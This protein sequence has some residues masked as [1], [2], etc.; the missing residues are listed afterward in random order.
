MKRPVAKVVL[1]YGPKHSGK[2]TAAMRLVERATAEG[3]SVAGISAPAVFR[4][5]I[6]AGYDVVDLATG[7]RTALARLADRDSAETGRFAFEEE[8]WRLGIAALAPTATAA[9]ALVMVDEFGPL[10][11]RGRGWRSAVD[12]LTPAFGGILLLVVRAE[13]TEE[14]TR[15]YARW[16]LER[17]P[18]C[19]PD[20]VDQMI[21]V[22]R[23]RQPKVIP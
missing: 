8:G 14:V 17:I 7:L 2:S 12:K 16:D 6:L 10:E 13:L 23:L 19:A 20:A 4:D 11:L 21:Q 22:L 15:L 1:W 18:A 5:S 9:A 3:F